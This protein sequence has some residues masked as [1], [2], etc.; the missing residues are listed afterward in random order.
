MSVKAMVFID[1]AWLYR[2]RT[3]IFSKLGEENGFEIDYQ[4]LPRVV[5]EDVANRLDE[6]V[7]L[8]R[9]LYFGTLPSARSGFNTSKQYSFYD[10]LE[11]SCGYDTDIHEVNMDGSRTEDAWIK[12]A[13]AT[14]IVYYAGVPGAYDVA[15]V[16][17]DDPDLTPPI[18]RA[19]L[20]G[21][22]IQLVTAHQVDGRHPIPGTVLY[23]KSRISDFPPVF[24]DEHAPEIRLVRERVKRT[25]K[26]C[27]REEETTWA[28]AD[29]FCSE[30][31]GKYRN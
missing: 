12:T 11:K 16:L 19:R 4:K 14:N 15:I 2:T 17:S 29:F 5:C 21:K 10:F 24:I 13:M 31:R 23:T 28:G 8:V 30:C 3:V 7:S 22:R 1:G 20:L 6:D 18:R 25:C 26:Q 27:G 9:T